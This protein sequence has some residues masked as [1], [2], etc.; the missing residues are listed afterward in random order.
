MRA[1]ITLVPQAGQ[2][3]IGPGT[4]YVAV[5]PFAYTGITLAYVNADQRP[6]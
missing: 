2:S 1:S 4:Y 3:V 6:T 5:R